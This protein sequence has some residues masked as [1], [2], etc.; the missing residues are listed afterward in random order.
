MNT[1]HPLRRQRQTA[2]TLIE[3]MVVIVIIGVLAAILLPVMSKMRVKANTTKCAANLRQIGTGFILYAAD[4][5]GKFPAQAGTVSN[6]MIDPAKSF[7]R[8][9]DGYLQPGSTGIIASPVWNCPNSIPKRTDTQTSLSY[10]MNRNLQDKSTLSLVSPSKIVL[11]RHTG[12]NLTA[13][14]VVT[15]NGGLIYSDAGKKY[16]YLFADIH[17]ELL[18][19][20]LG[21]EYWD[22]PAQ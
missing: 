4:N 8:S 3:L 12:P 17:V 2:F 9:V 1:P 6:F 18:S 13:S 7:A 11:L 16:N 14:L 20:V 19:P 22:T 15:D 21:S 5:N 10:C